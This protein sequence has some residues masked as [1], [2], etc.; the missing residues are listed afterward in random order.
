MNEIKKHKTKWLYWFF[1]AIAIIAV[2]KTLDSLGYIF[3]FLGGFFH[4]IAPFLAGILIAYLFY[5]PA[6]S[7][8]GIIR[9]TEVKFVR[10]KARVISIALV[11]IIALLLLILIV[12]VIL[13]VV[14]SSVGDLANNLQ[15]YYSTAM[16][17]LNNLPDDSIIKKDILAQAIDTLRNIDLK[18]YL[19]IKDITQYAMGILSVAG[20]I[21]N[22]FVAIVVS[23][24][25]L[26]ERRE[27][28][29]FIKKLAFVI[30][31]KKAFESIG[32]YFNS[33]NQIFF[34]FI[35]GQLLDAVVVGTILSIAFS[36]MG[37]KYAPLL[38]FIIG[39][40]NMIPYFGAIIGV[41]ISALITLIS[42]GVAQTVWMIIITIVLQQ[43]DA[44]IINPKILGNSLKISPLIVIAAVTIGGAYFG[45][46]GMFLAVPIAA[47]FK[48]IVIDLIDYKLE[49]K[50]AVKKDGL[51]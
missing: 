13:P 23:I 18:Q 35:A 17:K 16:Y 30:F 45:V 12:Q 43:I 2:Y 50:K 20:S 32:K 27:I 36:I 48:I 14:L 33:T 49:K 47:A 3:D 4:I 24:Y 15:G 1:L 38:G 10:K 22:I 29:V 42:G 26:A 28:L 51:N 37:L 39:L 9:K 34:N 31:N 46:I 41:V 25:L 40:F 21:F 8:E 5:I 44:N 6:R 7:I 11:Y 19:N